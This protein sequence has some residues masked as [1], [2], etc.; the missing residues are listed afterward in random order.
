VTVGIKLQDTHTKDFKNVS[1]CKALYISTQPKTTELL[2]KI[3]L[4]SDENARL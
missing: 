3:V 2:Q 1:H 4:R